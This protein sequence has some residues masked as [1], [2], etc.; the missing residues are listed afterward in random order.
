MHLQTLYPNPAMRKIFR[1]FVDISIASLSKEML[2]F[3]VTLIYVVTVIIFRLGS[4][5]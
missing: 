1:S 4:V 3:V 5:H 2:L